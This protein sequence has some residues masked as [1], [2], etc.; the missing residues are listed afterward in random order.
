MP[1]GESGDGGNRTPEVS[2]RWV[3]S[4]LGGDKDLREFAVG[5]ESGLLNDVENCTI[6]EHAY[7]LWT[8]TAVS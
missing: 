7:L 3:F 8:I 1:R 4:R 2:V 6:G 5:R